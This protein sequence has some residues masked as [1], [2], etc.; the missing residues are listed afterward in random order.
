VVGRQNRRNEVRQK[1]KRQ[2]R[3]GPP[4]DNSG[5][6]TPPLSSIKKLLAGRRVARRRTRSEEG[7]VIRCSGN[8]QGRSQ[9]KFFDKNTEQRKRT[10]SGWAMIYGRK[11]LLPLNIPLIMSSRKKTASGES[12][13]EQ[14]KETLGKKSVKGKQV[15]KL[16]SRVGFRL[17]RTSKSRSISERRKEQRKKNRRLKRRQ[18]KLQRQGVL[19]LKASHTI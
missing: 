2:S 9:Q 17:I 6:V 8:R 12:G 5:H 11:C 19:I 18:K 14:K 15:Q 4:T 3:K 10:R 7:L 1:T 13:A 16:A